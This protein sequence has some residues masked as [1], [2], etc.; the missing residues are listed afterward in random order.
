MSFGVLKKVKAVLFMES[1]PICVISE[2]TMTDCVQAQSI[3]FYNA[4]MCFS[5]EN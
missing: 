1:S 2:M 3:N 4:K 5:G